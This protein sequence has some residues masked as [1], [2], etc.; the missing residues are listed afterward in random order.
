MNTLMNTNE[1]FLEKIYGVV[2]NILNNKSDL[3]IEY[4]DTLKLL[5]KSDNIHIVN[6]LND[7]SQNEYELKYSIENEDAYN[8]GNYYGDLNVLVNGELKYIIE[9]VL[10]INYIDDDYVGLNIYSRD[11]K[12][13][14]N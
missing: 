12:E 2:F 5:T 1:E 6:M 13:R 9:M 8:Y 11:W 10:G 3:D 14:I 4:F 7:L